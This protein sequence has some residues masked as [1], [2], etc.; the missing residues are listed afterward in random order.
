MAK[1]KIQSYHASST[2]LYPNGGCAAR[3]ERGDAQ[4]V[5]GHKRCKKGKLGKGGRCV[6]GFVSVDKYRRQRPLRCKPRCGGKRKPGRALSCK[7]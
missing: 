5:H 6:A 1:S 4:T 7:R 2:M 3:L